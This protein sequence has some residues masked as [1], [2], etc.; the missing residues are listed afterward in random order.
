MSLF[1]SFC[2]FNLILTFA[3]EFALEGAFAL[4][5]T[6]FCI[7]SGSVLSKTA[8]LSKKQGRKR[9]ISSE[10]ARGWSLRE[11]NV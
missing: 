5:I 8:I 2:L 3:G 10:S 9:E 6:S 1:L 4:C 7:M 11:T